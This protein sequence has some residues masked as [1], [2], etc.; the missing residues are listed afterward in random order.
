MASRYHNIQLSA[1]QHQSEIATELSS[2]LQDWYVTERSNTV[3]EIG[4]HWRIEKAV[5]CYSISLVTPQPKLITN[6]C[7]QM[8]FRLLKGKAVPID[9]SLHTASILGR[10]KLD[11]LD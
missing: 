11:F 10:Q 1:L 3:E 8:E 7:I 5:S 9:D 4:R 6:P 2:D